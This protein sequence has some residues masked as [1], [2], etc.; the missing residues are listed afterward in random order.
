M[1]Q[2]DEKLILD[3]LNGEENA[4]G[5]L[6]EKY[7]KKIFNFTYR[8]VGNRAEAED[9]TSETFLKVWRNLRKF[10]KNLSFKTWIFRIAR[11]SAIDHIRKRKNVVFSDFENE[12]GNNYFEETLEDP[13][14]SA[15]ELIEKVEDKKF[16]EN[17]INQLPAIY[18]EVLLLRLN[19]DFTF[20][21]MSNIL[22]KPLDTVK[23]QH[24][25]ALIKLKKI[26][27]NN[28]KTP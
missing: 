6:T 26:L 23:S 15:P 2:N 5:V 21:E 24:R 3:Y 18:R 13:G 22:D 16:I 14:P 1:E 27:E 17:I 9:V 19:N 20:E 7:L 10:K 25:R 28:Q 8:I 4:F 11:N 12:D